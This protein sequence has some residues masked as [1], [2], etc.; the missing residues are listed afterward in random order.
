[1]TKRKKT[2]K[3]LSFL[4]N[5]L[6]FHDLQQIHGANLDADAAGNALRSRAFRLHDHDLH[7]AGFHALAAADTE[8]LVDHVHAGLGILGNGAVFTGLH[9]LAALNAGHRLDTGALCNNL[10]AAQIRMKFLVKR[11]GAGTHALQTGHA[12]NAFFGH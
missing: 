7:G 8:L 10:D 3:R 11:S 2:A 1:M 12:L 4:C 5:I 9:A 6:F